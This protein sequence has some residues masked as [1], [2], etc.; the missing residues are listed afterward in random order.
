MG[1]ASF[2]YGLN[3]SHSFYTT[4]STSVRDQFNVNYYSLE[5]V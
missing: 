4:R 2:D 5:T 3:N 1:L